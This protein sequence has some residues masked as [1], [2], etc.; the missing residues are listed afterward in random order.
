MEREE[1]IVN[2]KIQKRVVQNKRTNQKVLKVLGRDPSRS[3]VENLLGVEYSVVE[4]AG[5]GD[6]L[7]VGMR[8][9]IA[10]FAVVGVGMMVS[11]IHLMLN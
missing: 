9:L 8:T 4:Q 11:T 5:G 1:E 3:K 6:E 2:E 10:V 7:S